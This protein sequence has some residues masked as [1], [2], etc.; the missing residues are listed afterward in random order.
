MSPRTGRRGKR[1]REEGPFIKCPH[2]SGFVDVRNKVVYAD[3]LAAKLERLLNVLKKKKQAV[4]LEKVGDVFCLS[5]ID[6]QNETGFL[7]ETDDKDLGKAV[8]AALE[9]MK[10]G[11]KDEDR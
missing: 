2:C 9:E 7:F 10:E 4:V 5:N 8:D 6:E 11:G 1:E 3:P